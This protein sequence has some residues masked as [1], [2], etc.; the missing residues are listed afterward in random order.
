M[1]RPESLKV[2]MKQYSVHKYLLENSVLKAS[3]QSISEI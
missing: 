3:D 1:G 2:C